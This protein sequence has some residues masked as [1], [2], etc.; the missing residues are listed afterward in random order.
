MKVSLFVG[1]SILVIKATAYLLS[2]SQAL[3]ADA[4][5]SVVH[6]LA[7]GLATYLAFLQHK[8][9]DKNHPHGHGK[10]GF[11]SGQVEGLLILLTGLLVGA[12]AIGHL[13]HPS[14]IHADPLT[15]V[16]VGTAASVNG[17]LGF[18][19][20]RAGR[21]E[22]SLLLEANGH[23]TMADVWTSLGALVALVVVRA[24]GNPLWDAVTSLVIAALVFYTGL[25]IT[26]RAVHGL[27]DGIDVA[28][29][30]DVASALTEAATRHGTSPHEIQI[31]HDS[32]RLWVQAH[33]SFP[34]DSPLRDVHAALTRIEEQMEARFPGI[35]CS[36]HPEPSGQEDDS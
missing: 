9:A 11:L 25:K 30:A 20:V 36:L 12:S 31:R 32:V 10:F 2:G 22:G 33:L 14:P 13:T 27:T 7:V 26:W 16:L 35:V 15:M 1:L 4:A 28:V 21:R 29:Y 19:L 5:E 17:V 18:L 23:H 24:T 34:P 8:P 6:Q 3:L